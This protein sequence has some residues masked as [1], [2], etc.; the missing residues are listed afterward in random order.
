M[1]GIGGNICDS[2]IGDGSVGG[3]KKE[4]AEKA[5]YCYEVIESHRYKAEWY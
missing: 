2:S 1:R 4:V 3:C 5:N